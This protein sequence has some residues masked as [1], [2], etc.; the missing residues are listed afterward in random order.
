MALPYST[1]A[2][3][4]RYNISSKASPVVGTYA[5]QTQPMALFITKQIH[6]STIRK[7]MKSNN[8]FVQYPSH[9]TQIIHLPYQLSCQY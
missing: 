9:L 8:A 3:G 5:E 4:L 6:V 2:L 7:Y 1:Y